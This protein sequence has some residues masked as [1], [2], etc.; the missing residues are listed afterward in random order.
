MTEAAAPVVLGEEIRDLGSL[1][2]RMVIETL[3][4]SLELDGEP[5]RVR[6]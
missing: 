3:G 1:V 6:L 4:G 2:G 5:L